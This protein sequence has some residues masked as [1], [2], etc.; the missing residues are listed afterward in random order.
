[1]LSCFATCIVV[2]F[3]LSSVQ[4]SYLPW[5]PSSVIPVVDFGNAFTYI[6]LYHLTKNSRISFSHPFPA[7]ERS[8]SGCS[9]RAGVRLWFPK[10][11]SRLYYHSRTVK[12]FPRFSGNACH[13]PGGVLPVT[14][15]SIPVRASTPLPTLHFSLP[16]T[17]LLQALT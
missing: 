4:A 15:P 11:W 8:L 1:M 17:P 16:Q 6:L 5:H 12:P 10:A 14:F 2:N 7:T 13:L 3:L 9:T